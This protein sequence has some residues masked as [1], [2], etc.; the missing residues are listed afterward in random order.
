[1]NV[2]SLEDGFPDFTA[3]SREDAQVLGIA[4]KQM[5]WTVIEGGALI[6]GRFKDQTPYAITTESAIK[7]AHL[8]CQEQAREECTES[9]AK[10]RVAGD[11]G[12]DP[13]NLFV[14]HSWK[15]LDLRITP[16]PGGV[17]ILSDPSRTRKV[18]EGILATP[19]P[20]EEENRLRT[21]LDY[22]K[23]GHLK[24][25]FRT[26]PYDK[27]EVRQLDRIEK[28]LSPRFR[29]VRAAGIFQERVDY[30]NFFNGV[31]G[32]NESGELIQITNRARGLTSL[33][34]YWRNL[35]TSLGVSRVHFAG[36]YAVGAGVDCSG[37][38]TGK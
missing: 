37:A 15:H 24:S 10:K 13:G 38:P 32:Q 31:T 29:I 21:I 5:K 4:S 12:V 22:Y 26:Y 7:G 3:L 34:N 28:V 35:L 19:H 9:L 8:T 18:L 17:L 33:E 27:N 14:V 25:G 16:L 2:L 36:T 1:M 6:S 23:H 30:I 11:L 20:A